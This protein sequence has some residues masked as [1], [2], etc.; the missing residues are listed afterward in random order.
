MKSLKKISTLLLI[1]VPIMFITISCSPKN[2]E[3]P[4]VSNEYNKKLANYFPLVEGHKLE[5]SKIY[6]YVPILTLKKSTNVKGDLRLD[7]KGEILDK[8]K[9]TKIKNI[10]FSIEYT[11]GKN[12]VN[13]KIKNINT[14]LFQ[15]FIKE[16]VVLSTPIKKGA[17]WNQ[18]VLIDNTNYDATTK[19]I[20]NRE[21]SKNKYLT[22]IETTVKGI[23]GYPNNTYKEIRSFETNK[24]LVKFERINTDGSKFI[25]KL[26]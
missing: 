22:K 23:K 21:I 2:I 24:G 7:F 12:S 14:S 25:L 3:K 10:N 5:Y 18:S 4:E 6:K 11:I 1:L 26:K 20:E 16:Q 13:E 8:N 15:P 9:N 17:V 19:I